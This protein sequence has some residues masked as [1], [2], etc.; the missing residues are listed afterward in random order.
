MAA[1]NEVNAN[2]VNANEVNANDAKHAIND[3]SANVD[4]HN[5]SNDD[6]I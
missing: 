2:E 3:A 6:L 4:E 1:E 5:E